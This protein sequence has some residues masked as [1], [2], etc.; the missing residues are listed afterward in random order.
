[1]FVVI[2]IFVLYQEKPLPRMVKNLIRNVQKKRRKLF[3]VIVDLLGRMCKS[4]MSPFL[5]R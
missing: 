2:I 1:L 3:V 4:S 5:H